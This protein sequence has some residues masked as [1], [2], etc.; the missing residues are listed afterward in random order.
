MDIRIA[1]R[2]VLRLREGG[3]R[4]G[5]SPT[6]YRKARLEWPGDSEAAANGQPLD[7]KLATQCPALPFALPHATASKEWHGV[8]TRA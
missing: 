1:G 8:R 3:H 4:L 5:G 7:L 6:E 2:R